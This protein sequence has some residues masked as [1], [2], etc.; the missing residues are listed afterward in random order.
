[1]RT[2]VLSALLLATAVGTVTCNDGPAAPT[3]TELVGLWNL[4][5][6]STPSVYG[7]LSAQ[8][9]FREDGSFL[10]TGQNMASSSSTGTFDVEGAWSRTDDSA[11]LERD[12]GQPSTRTYLLTFASRT[13]TFTHSDSGESFTLFRPDPD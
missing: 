13:V 8:V 1:M 2:S 3:S 12:F 5:Y 6:Q 7:F 9:I 4:P 10:F 11:T